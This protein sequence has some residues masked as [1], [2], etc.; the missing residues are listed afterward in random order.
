MRM[1]EQELEAYIRQYTELEKECMKSRF[2]EKFSNEEF[3]NQRSREKDG[4]IL[5]SRQFMK[6]EDKIVVTRQDRFNRVRAHKHDYIEL[7]YVWSGICY[8]TIEGKAVT[9]EKGDVCIFDT[10]AVH[11]IESAGED[12]IL[13]NI[14]MRREF[15]DTAFL[16]RMTVQGIVSEFLVDAVTESR[17]KEHYLYFPSHKNPKVHELMK[18]IMVEYFSQ[19][20][21]TAE[22]LESYINILFTELLRTIRD[23]STQKDDLSR[24]VQIVELLSYIEKSYETCTLT[25]MGKVFGMHG[26]YLTALLKEKTGRSFVEHVQEQRLKKARMLLENTDIPMA[27]LIPLCGYNNMNFFYKKFKEASGCTPA[28]Y[29]KMKRESHTP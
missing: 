22:V 15:F 27:E 14:L 12:D 11:S 10:H 17:K 24:E 28:Y 18:N 19:D 25:Q 9:T 16:S 3:W 6:P 7:C 29:R 8:Q 1:T 5:E 23:E 20:I 26:N 21:G 13:V 4:Y 2:P